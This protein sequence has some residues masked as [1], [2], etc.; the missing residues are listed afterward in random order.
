MNKAMPG[1]DFNRP[2]VDQASL[3]EYRAIEAEISQRYGQRVLA[4][5]MSNSEYALRYRR[6]AHPNNMRPPPSH[7]RVFGGYLVVRSLGRPEKYETWIPDHA[8]EEIYVPLTSSR[9]VP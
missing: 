8:F 7:G 6:L 5:S 4:T 3:S 9:D 2:Y 1:Y